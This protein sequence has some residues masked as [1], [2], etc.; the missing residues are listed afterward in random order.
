MVTVLTLALTAS[1]SS[2]TV[3]E[4][5]CVTE[6]SFDVSELS[7]KVG[8]SAVALDSVAL[9]AAPVPPVRVHA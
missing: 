8:F 4:K 3:S 9:S 1:S 2:V 7:V 6:V 5:I